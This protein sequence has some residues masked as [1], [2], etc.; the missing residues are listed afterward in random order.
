MESLFS[1]VVPLPHAS[2]AFALFALFRLQQS[3]RKNYIP[4]VKMRA[5]DLRWNDFIV[6]T[7]GPDMEYFNARECGF[8]L[9]ST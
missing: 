1:L 3:V 4:L 2:S 7:C 8:R 5:A 6:S 9:A